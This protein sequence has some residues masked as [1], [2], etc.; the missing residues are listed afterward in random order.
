MLV[1]FI[2]FVSFLC[3]LTL[4]RRTPISQNRS[5]VPKLSAERRLSVKKDFSQKITAR[6]VF[7]IK[8]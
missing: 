7:K 3:F 2:A 5:R 4:L 8:S 1:Y 6:L